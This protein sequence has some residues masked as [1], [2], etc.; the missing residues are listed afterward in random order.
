MVPHVDRR[1]LLRATSVGAASVLTD[2]SLPGLIDALVLDVGTDEWP[3]FHHNATASGYAPGKSGPDSSRVSEQWSAGISPSTSVYA[4]G[5]L[6]VTK[7]GTAYAY[8]LQTGDGIW[9]TKYAKGNSGRPAAPAVGD[10]ILYAPAEEGVFGLDM[11]SGDTEWS[12]EYVN[13]REGLT[14]YNG[15]FSRGQQ[16]EN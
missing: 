8:D 14:L 13:Q 6:Y 2:E 15:I 10:E 4:D 9:S 7:D 16:M 11:S 3:M 12:F 1:Q 5:R